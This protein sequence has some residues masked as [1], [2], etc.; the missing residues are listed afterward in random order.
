[1][2]CVDEG[3]IC[4]QFNELSLQKKNT[5]MLK[6]AWHHSH[7]LQYTLRSL[8]H[9]ARK[10]IQ[11]YVQEYRETL[12]SKELVQPM[13]SIVYPDSFPESNILPKMLQLDLYVYFI[14]R[15]YYCILNF[16]VLP[17]ELKRRYGLPCKVFDLPVNFQP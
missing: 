12:F 9:Q 14:F 11:K 6:L 3:N 16:T 8:L 5:V 15:S 13:E 1:M 17:R 7:N 10:I 2:S 4:E